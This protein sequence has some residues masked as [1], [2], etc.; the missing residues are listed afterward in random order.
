[1]RQAF[2]VKYPGEWQDMQAEKTLAQLFQDKPSRW[3][4]RGDPFL[5]EEMCGVLGEH[6]YPDTQE[7]LNLL[8]EQTFQRL[9]G[10]SIKEPR[11]VFVER[12]AHGGISSGHVDPQFWRDKAFPL[13]LERFRATE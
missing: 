13:L 12:Y 10:R 2:D 11:S 7:Q 3:G 1:L 9:T 6:A 5:W 4:L 8:L